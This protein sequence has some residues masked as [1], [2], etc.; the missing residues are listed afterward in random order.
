MGQSFV[1]RAD[2]RVIGSLLQHRPRAPPTG[3]HL[4]TTQNLRQPAA[5]PMATAQSIKEPL[6][7]SLYTDRPFHTRYAVQ[8][9]GGRY[10]PELLRT[11]RTA[12][13]SWLYIH[14]KHGIDDFGP[15]PDWSL[16]TDLV[17]AGRCGPRR[18]DDP[19][20]DGIKLWIEADRH[21]A[22]YRPDEPVC[23]HSVASLPLHEE[24]SGWRNLIEGF[25][26][27]HLSSQGMVVDWAIHH[28][29]EGAGRREILPHVHMLITMRV[30]D[31]AHGDVG[32][33]RQT[34]IRTERARKSLAE[35]WWAYSGMFPQNHLLA[36]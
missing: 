32:R 23:A 29:A 19:S 5:K 13:A 20:L 16:R 21:A 9:H 31:S 2:P 11:H 33:I 14:R 10:T 4:I 36:A 26:E 28:Q 7:T 17:A 15:T 8:Q 18:A 22:R 3:H 27:D 30:F 12:K 25:S 34:W 1:G 24:V 6:M 35:K